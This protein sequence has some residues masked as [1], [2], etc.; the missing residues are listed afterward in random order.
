[1]NEPIDAPQQTSHE[2]DGRTLTGM[3]EPSEALIEHMD[4]RA[5]TPAK[6]PPA[7]GAAAAPA[8]TPD[9]G[10]VAAPAEQPKPSRG[11]QRFSDLT[12][13]RDEARNETAKERTQRETLEREVTDLRA[14]VQ[15]ASTPQQAA[16]AQTQL[17]R[18]EN[19]QADQAKPQGFQF[20]KFEEALEQ[21]PQL[22]YDDWQDAKL[23]AFADWRDAQRNIP[24][25]VQQAIQQ[26]RSQRSFA[27]TVESAR[28]R[29]RAV[30]KDF[31]AV[32]NGGPGA[33]I[34]QNPHQLQAIIG[35][36]QAEHITYAILK[37][38]DLARRLAQA[39]PIE[40]GMELARLAP[41]QQQAAPSRQVAPPTPYDPVGTGSATTVQASSE[42][43]KKGNFDAYRARRASERGVKSRY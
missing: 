34:I 31:D 25:L 19:R 37:D 13:E 3:G 40:F 5:E 35:H 36:P 24:A 33:G 10:T 23:V 7:S 38:G 21:F 27:D 6:E 18:A 20:P 43:A 29:G 14:R 16:A 39:G 8:L 1:M 9:P 4:R 28:T 42:L 15:Q 12:R 22:T 17:D 30:Y 32:W 41:A 26:D 2:Q 11:A